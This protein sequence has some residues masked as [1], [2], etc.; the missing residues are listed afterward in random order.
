[1][2]GCYGSFCALLT[3]L[4][5]FRLSGGRSHMQE[6]GKEQS[7]SL[8]MIHNC[9]EQL[10]L[11]LETQRDGVYAHWSLANSHLRDILD[12]F[13]EFADQVRQRC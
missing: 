3:F 12:R 1:M 8:R 10:Q 13:Q 5:T 7:K 6:L 4:A 9:Q 11:A 2:V